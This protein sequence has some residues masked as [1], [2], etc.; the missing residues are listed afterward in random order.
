MAS[1]SGL[2][3]GS[4]LRARERAVQAALLALHHAPLH[5]DK[6]DPIARWEGIRKQKNSRNGEF[7]KVAD[8][9]SFV[10]WC[11]WNAMFLQFNLGDTV[12]G[13]GWK[14]GYTGTLLSH[15]M[16]VQHV[17]NILRG[18]CVH[19]DDPAH[20]SIVV[21]KRGGVPHAVSHGHEGGP[22]YHTYNYRTPTQIR[23]YI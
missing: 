19:Y 17:A 16:R 15:G 10:T 6:D 13:E 4:R 14:G 23:R 7:P 8:C 2:G 22:V 12:N 1:A 3:Q 21:D 11:L 9:S 18:D 5:Y 20:V